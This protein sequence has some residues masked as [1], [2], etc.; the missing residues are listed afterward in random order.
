MHIRAGDAIFLNKFQKQ[1]I[2]PNIFARALNFTLA[3]EIINKE[4][5]TNNAII[6]LS[7][8]LSLLECFK[9]KLPKFIKS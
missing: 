6:V 2:R 4:L 3:I 5:K 7:D 1:I 9:N 8:D